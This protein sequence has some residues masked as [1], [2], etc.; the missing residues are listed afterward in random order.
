M[1]GASNATRVEFEMP[2]AKLQIPTVDVQDVV[3]TTINF[4]A[5]AHET[6]YSGNATPVNFDLTKSNELMLRYYSAN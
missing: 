4:K 1:G 2:G 5:Q 6:T 3:S